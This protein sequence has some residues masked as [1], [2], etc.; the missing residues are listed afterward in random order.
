MS[1]VQYILLNLTIDLINSLGSLNISTPYM[2]LAIPQGT[3]TPGHAFQTAVWVFYFPF[4]Q[5]KET[6]PI[7]LECHSIVMQDLS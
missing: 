2:Q 4:E 3:I 5:H 1:A 6:R 7:A